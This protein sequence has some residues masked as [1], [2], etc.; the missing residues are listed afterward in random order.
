MTFVLEN[1]KKVHQF[2]E[3][4]LQQQLVLDG[5]TEEALRPKRSE[6]TRHLQPQMD[7]LESLISDLEKKI[8]SLKEHAVPAS[9]AAADAEVQPNAAN[10]ALP[11][12]DE[13]NA[14]EERVYGVIE[15]AIVCTSGSRN[16]FV[17]FFFLLVL[18]LS[19]QYL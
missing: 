17:S 9:A 11:Q 19:L 12:Q 3:G 7:E 18:T 4:L 5:I 13:L 1:R 2:N 8:A 16:K 10:E 15:K 6:L 14:I